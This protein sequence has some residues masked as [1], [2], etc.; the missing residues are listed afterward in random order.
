M[1]SLADRD[2]LRRAAEALLAHTSRTEIRKRHRL[3]AEFQRQATPE[4][5]LD[6]LEAVDDLL[7]QMAE[8]ARQE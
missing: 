1:S 7:H 3:E 6:L 5:V 8:A 2:A 4:R